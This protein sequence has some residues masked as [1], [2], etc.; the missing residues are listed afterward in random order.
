[1][2]ETKDSTDKTLHAGARKPLSLQRT[3]ESGHVRQNFSHGRSK[4]V[5]VEK[6]KTR[7]LVTPGQPENEPAAP[8]PVVTAR[9]EPRVAQPRSTPTPGQSRAEPQRS[10]VVP[11]SQAER[12]AR[13]A[14][15][16]AN[17]QRELE[18]R[19]R[20]EL[21]RIEA[22]QARAAA[23]A[24]APAPVVAEA[25]APAVET[26]TAAP[27]VPVVAA[28]K[29]VIEAKPVATPAAPRS[30][31]VAR[32]TP[33]PRSA[34][35][36]GAPTHAPRG[37]RSER[38]AGRHDQPRAYNPAFMPREGGRPKEIMLPTQRRA[39]E[40]SAP[41]AKAAADVPTKLARPPRSPAAV[42]DVGDD[43]EGRGNALKR[44][45]KVARAPVSK[46]TDDRRERG[47]LTINNAFDEQQRERSL[48]SLKRKREREKLK[49]MGISQAREKITREV[50][51]PE[52]ITIQELSNRMA[53]RGVDII[54]FLMKQGAMHKIT[55]VIDTDTAELI[56]T[57]FGHTAK[58]VSEAD[59]E[60]GFIGEK[61]SD[62][63]LKPRAPVV[64][65][66]GHVDHGKT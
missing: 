3:V 56:V 30:E 33:S 57:E 6:R 36:G 40:P 61:D 45:G 43:D 24:A 2:T 28:P 62:E 21:A 46:P 44:G 42:A 27:E 38:G 20:A 32:A 41:S 9:P 22:E 19:E 49:A 54:K 52:V 35:P 47:K 16:Q 1:M 59:V 5:V 39:A 34:E 13:A 11:I 53:E 10:G 12:D 4:S 37:E 8:A 66:M 60:T 14:A 18:E 26:A 50:I 17:R 7:K 15:L 58:R 64:T 29:P 55:D 23:A 51:I 48:A 63:A 25:P 65:I 31:P